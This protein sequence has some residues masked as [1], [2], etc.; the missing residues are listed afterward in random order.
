VQQEGLVQRQQGAVT[1]GLLGRAAAQRCQQF[2]LD[3][4]SAAPVHAQHAVPAQQRAHLVGRLAVPG[5]HLAQAIAQQ[6]DGVLTLRT[7]HLQSHA[8]KRRLGRVYAP[9]GLG[10]VGGQGGLDDGAEHERG[11]EDQAA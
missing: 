6:G 8:G 10:A 3:E 9:L 5:R 4:Q 1:H 11:G 7:L 2:V